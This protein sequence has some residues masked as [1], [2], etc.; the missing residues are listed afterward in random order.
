MPCTAAADS[1]LHFVSCRLQA[2]PL[3][4]C[5]IL[6]PQVHC[7]RLPAACSPLIAACC[8][9]F[10]AGQGAGARP[11][12]DPPP[13]GVQ[14]R[15]HHV[16]GDR[17]RPLPGCPPAA[18]VSTLPQHLQL[19][20]LRMYTVDCSW[21]RMLKPAAVHLRRT[22]A[23]MQLRVLASVEWQ[24]CFLVNSHL[25][26]P[27]LQPGGARAARP[28]G[29][30]EAAGGAPAGWAGGPAHCADV[31]R[32]PAI[33]QDRRAG[34]RPPREGSG[35]GWRRAHDHSGGKCRVGLLMLLG[36]PCS[37]CVGVFGSQGLG[38]HVKRALN[39]ICLACLA[40]DVCLLEL[41][42]ASGPAWSPHLTVLAS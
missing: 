15:L 26:P 9:L 38:L 23:C 19:Q 37:S 11:P 34:A 27:D 1:A 20:L 30:A 8:L 14:G 42:P 31:P 33:P 32:H 13:R 5:G 40:P 29:L 39:K 25:C 3:I 35:A 16:P 4:C 21:L 6:A 28:A 2:A 18:H 10:T 24:C 36:G 12:F 7:S 41:Q 22:M 17:G